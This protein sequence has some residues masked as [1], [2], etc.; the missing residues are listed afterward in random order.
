MGSEKPWR[1]PAEFSAVGTTL[2]RS[3]QQL[4]L[5]ELDVPSVGGVAYSFGTDLGRMAAAGLLPQDIHPGNI[6][7]TGSGAHVLFDWGATTTLTSITAA[8]Y[9]WWLGD[10]RATWGKHFPY[11][12]AGITHGLRALS[13]TSNATLYDDLVALLGGSV[14]N[15]MPYW[16]ARPVLAAAVNSMVSRSH[17]EVFVD[18]QRL[19]TFEASESE[20]TAVT[21]FAAI[22]GLDPDSVMQKPTRI[23]I[24][25][26]LGL[27]LLREL[28]G[29]SDSFEQFWTS[30]FLLTVFANQAGA[31]GAFVEA[32]RTLQLVQIAL[33]SADCP[34]RSIEPLVSFVWLSEPKAIQFASARRDEAEVFTFLGY[35]S[36]MAVTTLKLF[37]ASRSLVSNNVTVGPLWSLMWHGLWRLRACQHALHDWAKGRTEAYGRAMPALG[38]LA[39]MQVNFM[40][41]VAHEL[42][43]AGERGE[44]TPW[45]GIIN[46]P[47]PNFQSEVEW[48]HKLIALT[49]ASTADAA[50]IARHYQQLTATVA[51]QGG[52]ADCSF[53][54]GGK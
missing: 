29:R 19:V 36:S 22:L 35:V 41:E 34:V 33:Q 47:A 11:L 2:F 1:A 44:V 26:E 53:T 4:I 30:L 38:A 16:A 27:P 15:E 39:K 20:L 3:D 40:A 52:M 54:P 37:R 28:A 50:I 45:T 12:L 23:D 48:C 18:L 49:T 43:S 7:V 10:L 14:A 8:G 5:S 51:R 21:V 46:T 31:A 17:S 42:R 13:A 32:V 9:L 6:A 24:K 25:F